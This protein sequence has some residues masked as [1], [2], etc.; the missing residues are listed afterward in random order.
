MVKFDV[1]LHWAEFPIQFSSLRVDVQSEPDTMLTELS[2]TE[3]QTEIL[4]KVLKNYALSLLYDLFA[5]K[6]RV[7][8]VVYDW[9]SF[10]TSI[11]GDLGLFLGFSCLSILLSLVKCIKN[12]ICNP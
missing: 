5:V 11:R 9:G 2:I 1:R 3:R 12:K 6:E 4:N 8:S 7:E 10:L